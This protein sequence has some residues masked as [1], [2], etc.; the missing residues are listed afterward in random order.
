M[1]K[2]FFA[3]VLTLPVGFSAFVLTDFT[4]FTAFALG[5]AIMMDCNV[6][7]FSYHG[8]TLCIPE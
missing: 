1:L 4:G 3:F 2:L 8:K 6:I 7:M 5:A